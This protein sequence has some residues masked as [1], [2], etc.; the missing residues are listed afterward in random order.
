MS[1]SRVKFMFFVSVGNI[2]DSADVRST[3]ALK[4]PDLVV[5]K[6][7]RIS[8]GT[9]R[10]FLTTT[11][12][13]FARVLDSPE[14]HAMPRTPCSLFLT[15]ADLRP[16]Q[17]MCTSIRFRCKSISECRGREYHAAGAFRRGIRGHSGGSCTCSNNIR[18]NQRKN[19]KKMPNA[20]GER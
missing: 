4:P 5:R 17:A 18:R 19:G 14:M 8:R 13:I 10:G 6:M 9:P 15:Q 20:L 12:G 7:Q 16:H 1:C 11:L 3:G 2:L